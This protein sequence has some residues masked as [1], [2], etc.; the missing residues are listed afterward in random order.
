MQ[1]WIFIFHNL[2]FIWKQSPHPDI[3]GKA[4]SRQLLDDMMPKD[5]T[6]PASSHTTTLV[7]KYIIIMQVGCH[8]NICLCDNILFYPNIG[9]PCL[10]NGLFSELTV[11]LTPLTRQQHNQPFL[12]QATGSNPKKKSSEI[13]VNDMPC[14]GCLANDIFKYIESF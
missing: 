6:I 9:S 8:L 7:F 10:M 2:G 14:C 12:V 5:G 1:I 3:K 4:F 13:R 11:L